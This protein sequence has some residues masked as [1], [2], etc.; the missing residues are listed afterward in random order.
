MQ[1]YNRLKNYLECCVLAEARISPPWLCTRVLPGCQCLFLHVWAVIQAW[2]LILCS[3]LLLSIRAFMGRC[4]QSYHG[5]SVFGSAL[6]PLQRCK[7]SAC[8]CYCTVHFKDSI[9]SALG[10][11]NKRHEVLS[12]VG[13]L[14]LFPDPLSPH[15]L[16][17]VQ[18]AEAIFNVNREL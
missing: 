9:F 7:W 16:G 10:D 14:V 5:N 6:H 2:C 3:Y 17:F 8:K 15:H 4:C 13:S 1:T 12:S 18:V 11:T